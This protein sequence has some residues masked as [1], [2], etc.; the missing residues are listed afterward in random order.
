MRLDQAFWLCKEMC[1]V[2]PNSLPTLKTS[3]SPGHLR[4]PFSLLV[5]AAVPPPSW[6]PASSSPEHLHV[7]STTTVY[8]YT[9][10]TESSTVH[11][12]P[13]SLYIVTVQ[14]PSDYNLLRSVFIFACFGGHLL[15]SSFW[16]WGWGWGVRGGGLVGF[17][18]QESGGVG[19]LF[20]FWFRLH[21]S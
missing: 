11:I 13:A 16:G 5:A 9:N 21:V 6:I 12:T 14:H 8:M 18:L 19:R 2:Y 20:S 17:L 10:D 1:N 4:F 7:T 3:S 15:S